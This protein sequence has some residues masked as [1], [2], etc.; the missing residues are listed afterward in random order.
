MYKKG[1]REK[2]KKKRK[3]EE[4]EKLTTVRYPNPKSPTRILCR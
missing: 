1:K 4:R 2:K 3:K